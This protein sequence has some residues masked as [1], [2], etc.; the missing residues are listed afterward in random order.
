MI[1]GFS[2][3][4]ERPVG[5]SVRRHRADCRNELAAAHVDIHWPVVGFLDPDGGPPPEALQHRKVSGPFCVSC[6]QALVVA[7]AIGEVTEK[8]SEPFEPSVRK[9]LAPEGVR[10]PR[11]GEKAATRRK[12]NRWLLGAAAV[13]LVVGASILLGGVRA[14][15]VMLT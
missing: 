7:A 8:P 6:G 10:I 4:R 1:L 13:V 12:M 9:V 2:T 3:A 15:R 14:A 5:P 11:H